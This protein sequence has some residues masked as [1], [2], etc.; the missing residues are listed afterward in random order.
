MRG[1]ST[2]GWQQIE[3]LYCGSDSQTQNSPQGTKRLSTPEKDGKPG[4]K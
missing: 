2:N 4:V 1:P 3:S